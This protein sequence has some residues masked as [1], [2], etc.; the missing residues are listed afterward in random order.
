[1]PTPAPVPGRLALI[2]EPLGPRTG[3]GRYVQMLETGLRALGVDTLR[4]GPTPPQLPNLSY[5]L[6][7]LLGR[8][9]RAL[10]SNYPIWPRYPTADIYH[11]TSQPLAL[12]LILRR[13]RGR[14]VVTV[15][16]I[17][18][19]ILRDDPR[20]GPSHGTDRL[21]LGLTMAGLHRADHLIANS[22]YTKR[23]VVDHLG[24]AAEKIAVTYFGID[25]ERF[26]PSAVPS[27]IR[28]RYGLAEGRRYL[29]YVGSEDPRKNLA[30]LVRA[31]A[32][33]RAALPDVELIKAGLSHCPE[34]RERL[35][36]L[37]AELEVRA[38]IHFVEDVPEEDLPLLY[39]LADL[40][41]TPSPYEG[42]G[43]PL[44]EAM[45]C[46]TPVVYADAGSLPEIAAS[47]GIGVSPCTPEVLAG[48]VL[49]VLQHSDKQA[50]LRA[51]GRK[52]A[53]Q[54]TWTD[55]IQGTLAVYEQVMHRTSAP[56]GPA[57]AVGTADRLP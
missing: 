7:A 32:Q 50:A 44:L 34:E 46:G 22:E 23:C 3:I 35:L 19:H 31:L 27:G 30:T 8:D 47:A 9:L 17:F 49:T 12:S 55:T 21:L 43:F 56:V 1:M 5:R 37:A 20:L 18:P 2:A 45:A 39:N 28:Q 33:V 4:G 6:L 54:F 40:Y 26:Q 53:A 29:M 36:R 51:A 15:H 38:A 41:V 25:H 52:R 14:V 24:V 16:D 11:L 42:F 48:A 57:H 10:L 13:P